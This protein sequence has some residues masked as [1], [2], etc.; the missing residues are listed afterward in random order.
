MALFLAGLILTCHLAPFVLDVITTSRPLI[1]RSVL[2][3]LLFIMYTI[4][5]STVI[6]FP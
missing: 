1:K 4:P 2:G 6:S 5:L 3:H